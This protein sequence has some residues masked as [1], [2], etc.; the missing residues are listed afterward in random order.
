MCIKEDWLYEGFNS[1]NDGSNRGSLETSLKGKK[2]LVKMLVKVV[3]LQDG[4]V[5]L[6]P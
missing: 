2:N 4:L 6:L 3:S 5:P 1:Q